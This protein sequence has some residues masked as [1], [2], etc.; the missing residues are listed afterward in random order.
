[1][2]RPLRAPTVAIGNF[3]G[4]HRGHQ[5][6][7]RTAA[8]LARGAGGE[9]GV[10]TFAPHP[11]PFFA[12]HLAPPMIMPLERRLELLAQFGAEVVVIESFDAAFAAIEADP[13]AE[14]GLG[15]TLGARHGGGGSD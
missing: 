8:D 11:A 6:L 2:G 1:L 14:E 7:V 12:P 9:P 4:V 3:D 15:G 5:A 13:F 10:L